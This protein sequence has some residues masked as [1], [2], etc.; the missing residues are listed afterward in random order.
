ME[1]HYV[2]VLSTTETNLVVGDPL[3][4][5]VTY[6]EDDFAKIWRYSG[7]VLGRRP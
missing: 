4:G 6:T 2:T 1:D 7:V 3:N 5:R